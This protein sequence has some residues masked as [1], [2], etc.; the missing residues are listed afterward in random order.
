MSTE[1]TTSN[2]SR[3]KE[4][5]YLKKRRQQ[6]LEELSKVDFKIKLCNL[7]KHRSNL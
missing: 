6:L 4:L 2:Q 1:V 7:F 5:E 3:E